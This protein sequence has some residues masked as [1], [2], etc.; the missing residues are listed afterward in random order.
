MPCMGGRGGGGLRKPKGK[1]QSNHQPSPSPLVSPPGSLLLSLY[2][3][4]G[5]LLIDTV[6]DVQQ[7]VAHVGHDLAHHAKV[8]EQQRALHRRVWGGDRAGEEDCGRELS[9]PESAN[10]MSRILA[11]GDP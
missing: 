7:P 3:L 5:V 8:V 1:H 9:T 6:E 11:F 2:D 4:V 10:S